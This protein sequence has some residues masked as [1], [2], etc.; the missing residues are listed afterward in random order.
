MV[1]AA[2][3]LFVLYDVNNSWYPQYLQANNSVCDP[4]TVLT[5]CLWGS[6]NQNNVDLQ[7]K[8][9]KQ[10]VTDGGGTESISRPWIKGL[11]HGLFWTRTL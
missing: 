2:F 4:L 8:K 9:L 3:L 5:F 7:E 10:L 6:A 11:G 1:P